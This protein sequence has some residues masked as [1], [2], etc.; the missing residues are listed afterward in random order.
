MYAMRKSIVDAT[1]PVLV[2]LRRATQVDKRGDDRAMVRV[3]I[4][5]AL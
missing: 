5:Q 2:L 4:W 3:V 1:R